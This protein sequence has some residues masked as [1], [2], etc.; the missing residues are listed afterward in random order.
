MISLQRTHPALFNKL[1]K[2]STCF[3]EVDFHIDGI[4]NSFDA[5]YDLEADSDADINSSMDVEKEELGEG[6]RKF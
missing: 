2:V 4:L 6:K 1:Y 3:I 5:N